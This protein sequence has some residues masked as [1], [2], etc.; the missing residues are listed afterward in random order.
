MRELLARNDLLESSSQPPPA[1]EGD[2]ERLIERI[3]AIWRAR[4]A[5][6]WTALQSVGITS[7]RAVPLLRVLALVTRWSWTEKGA[8]AVLTR[9]GRE[10][11]LALLHAH[12]QSRDEDAA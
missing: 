8:R 9:L 7:R 10:D 2:R 12:E 6:D 11:L 4:P 3:L 5:P 1:Y